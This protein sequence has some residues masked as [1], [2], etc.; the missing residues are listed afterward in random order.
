MLA[1]LLPGLRD[2]RAPLAAGYLWLVACWLTLEPSVPERADAHGV[3]ASLYRADDVLSVVGLGLVLA[4]A[5]YLLGSLSASTLSPLLR[6]AFPSAWPVTGTSIPPSP[7]SPQAIEALNQV[8]FGA[9]DEVNEALALTGVDA[10]AFL[11]GQTRRT[12]PGLGEPARR[13]PWRRWRARARL[14]RPPTAS[15]ARSK[16]MRGPRSGSES[17]TPISIDVRRAALLV[18]WVLQDL[19]VVANTRLLGRDQALY[20]EVDRNRAE[21]EL[22]LAIIPPLAI[23]A[24]ALGMVTDP[25]VLVVAAALGG[26]LAWGLFSDAV[27]RERLANQI[28][29][30]SMAAGRVQSAKLESLAGEALAEKGRHEPERLRRAAQSAELALQNVVSSLEWVGT[31]EP[32]LAFDARRWIDQAH[33]AVTRM[34]EVFPAPVTLM[35]QEALDLLTTVADGWVDMN[36][37]K[38]PPAHDPQDL[39]AEARKSITRFRARALARVQEAVEAEPMPAP[40]APEATP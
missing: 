34:G 16:R 20:A 12:V 10:D 1:S 27:R 32:A 11:A 29:L 5:A 23:L 3:V 14:R 35:A 37:G 33:E 36:A 25:W 4:F 24:I 9:V 17:A 30:Q 8:V 7:M 21:V 22:R 28:L 38:G 40:A 2:V 26:L 39:L 13:R 19:D 31:S 6:R 15:P 18:P